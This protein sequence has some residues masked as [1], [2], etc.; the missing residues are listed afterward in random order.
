MGLQAGKL[1]R[2]I[3]IQKQ[4]KV[5]DDAGQVIDD[6]VD[7][8]KVWSWHKSLNGRSGANGGIVVAI[9]GDSWRMRYN[10]SLKLDTS[11]RVL[12]NGIGFN[13]TRIIYDHAGRE[14]IDLICEEGGKDRVQI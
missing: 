11:M 2:Y 5:R 7:V 9:N 10:P 6:W 12:F 14:Y 4:T 8:A 1:N 13:I 3:T